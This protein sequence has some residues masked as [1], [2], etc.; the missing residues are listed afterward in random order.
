MRPSHVQGK[1]PHL[2]KAWFL[3]IWPYMGEKENSP[4]WTGWMEAW[5]LSFSFW[6]RIYHSCFPWEYGWICWPVA[7]RGFLEASHKV[8]GVWRTPAFSALDIAKETLFI[9]LTLCKNWN[10]QDIG[11]LTVVTAWHLH[12]CS[13]FGSGDAMWTGDGQH[14]QGIEL[15]QVL[16]LSAWQSLFNALLTLDRTKTGNVISRS[17]RISGRL[18]ATKESSQQKVWGRQAQAFQLS[19]LQRRHCLLTWPFANL[20]TV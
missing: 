19:A 5:W 15:R 1:Q 9:D 20:E 3:E 10:C 13:L 12:L 14:R 16:V 17:E 8:W 6:L 7:A 11:S 18:K 2:Q 4:K